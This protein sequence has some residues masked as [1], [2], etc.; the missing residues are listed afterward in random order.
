MVGMFISLSMI[1]SKG[2]TLTTDN[3]I[4]TSCEFVYG[5]FILIVVRI[6]RFYFKKFVNWCLKRF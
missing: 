4:E 6:V 3:V 1:C 5:V 2:D